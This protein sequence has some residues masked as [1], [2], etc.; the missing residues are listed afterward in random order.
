MDFFE[1]QDQARRRTKWL[2]LYFLLALA[3]IVLA[4]YAL[5]VLIYTTAVA[6][7][8]PVHFWNW[9]LFLPVAGGTSLLIIGGSLYKSM[10]LGK[11]GATVAEDLGGRLLDP[12]TTDHHER[13]LLNVVQE[14]AI[15]SG[16]PVPQ[17][18]VMD[19]E[20][21]INAFAAGTEPSNAVIGVTRGCIDRLSR[22]ELQGVIAHE[23][24]HILNGDMRLNMRLIGV[25]FGILI[26][27]IIGRSILYSMR[28]MRFRS[29]NSKNGGVAILVIL[30]LGVGFL[31]IGG[32]GVVFAR[33]IQAAVSRQREFLAD[34]SAVQFTREPDGLA[35]ALKKIGGATEGSCVR[36]PNALEASHMFFAEGGLFTWGLATHP[37][38]KVRIKAIQPHWEGDYE[39][40]TLPEVTISRGE[41]RTRGVF[42]SLGGGLTAV[43]AMSQLGNSDRWHM[44]VGQR[45]RDGIPQ[46]WVE[47]SQNRDEAQALIFAMLL[48]E[49]RELRAREVEGLGTGVGRG[50][51]EVAVKWHEGL[52]ALH[53]AERIALIDLCIPTLRR[54]SKPEYER[55]AKI[56]GWL[57]ESD[58]KVQ[59]FEFMLQHTIARH[60]ASHFENRG[61][62]PIRHG[63]MSDLSTEASVLVSAL[64]RTGREGAPVVESFKAAAEE[65]GASERWTPILLEPA[66]CGPEQLGDALQEFEAAT[67][68]VKKQILRV[69]GLAA[70]QDGILTNQEA[71]L[72]RTVADAI[73]ASLPPFVW[74]LE[75]TAEAGT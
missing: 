1:A 66:D 5:A 56:T 25:I 21:G 30:A 47:A 71:E 54:M 32:V 22:A 8:G 31:I 60:L 45:I 17:V 18:Y 49:D 29:S 6:R 46:R 26:L 68:V 53:S 24:S 59:L 27:M 23:F 70:A 39:K 3:G 11:G 9:E 10:Q 50:A 7:P 14:I 63:R 55:F 75:N 35:G 73:G 42:S 19:E 48:S 33:L 43:A 20:L 36:S 62:P 37:P 51:A 64:A 74:N 28:H 72:L 44:D 4:V 16:T 61:F 2:M 65:W 38:L 69:C 52:A 58:Q 40:S 15:A 34:A 41:A 67:P 13:V 12:G 57:I